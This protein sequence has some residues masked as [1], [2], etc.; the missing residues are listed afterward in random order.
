[1]KLQ[2]PRPKDDAEEISIR[3]KYPLPSNYGEGE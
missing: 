3:N 1:M 2:P